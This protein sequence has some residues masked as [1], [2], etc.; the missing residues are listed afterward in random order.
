MTKIEGQDEAF[1]RGYTMP[2]PVLFVQ[3]PRISI[4]AKLLMAYLTRY[5]NMRDRKVH[6]SQAS[7]AE[8]LN[9]SRRTISRWI[10]EL[11][12]AGYVQI[13][14][15]G[16]GTGCSNT[17]GLSWLPCLPPGTYDKNVAGQQDNSVVGAHDRNGAQEI[18]S[19][20]TKSTEQEQHAAGVVVASDDDQEP[21]T[22]SQPIG[23]TQDALPQNTG[24]AGSPSATDIPEDDNCLFDET[25]RSIDIPENLRDR[26]SGIYAALEHSVSD[27]LVPGNREAIQA[28]F[29]EVS[30]MLNEGLIDNRGPVGLLLHKVKNACQAPSRNFEVDDFRFDYERSQKPTKEEIEHVRWSAPYCQGVFKRLIKQGTPL[31]MLILRYEGSMGWVE[32]WLILASYGSDRKDEFLS[33]A[34]LEW[35]FT[36]PEARAIYRAEFPNV[37]F[38]PLEELRVGLLANHGIDPE[39]RPD[40][41]T[42]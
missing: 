4:G 18:K 38:S 26:Y 35:T 28:V 8:D 32:M 9:A 11:R 2:V 17:Y 3:D 13:E 14:K 10:A 22:T 23:A 1:K 5:L 20:E 29:D 16:T 12:V 36:S 24:I 30:G 34:G 42:T 31:D 41:G 25:I 6:P 7:L 37:D 39:D 19:T 15:K 40:D 33:K 21:D 27:L